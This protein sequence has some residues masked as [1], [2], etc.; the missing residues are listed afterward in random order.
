M[1]EIRHSYVIL[2]EE[3]EGKNLRGRFVRRWEDSIKM[4]PKKWGVYWINL[5]QDRDWWLV[6]MN[7][8]M[9]QWVP[10]TYGD[11]S[12]QLSGY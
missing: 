3:P 6:F 8:V 11:F 4:D 9:I 5:T 1:G 7:T 10:K 12:D 2:V